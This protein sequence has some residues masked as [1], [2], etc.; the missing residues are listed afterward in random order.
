[1]EDDVVFLKVSSWAQT[2]IPKDIIPETLL[3]N[4]LHNC[5]LHGKDSIIVLKIAITTQLR[6][7][8]RAILYSISHLTWECLSLALWSE[9]TGKISLARFTFRPE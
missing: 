8:L 5:M 4:M 9:L 2:T 6:Q 3:V 7:K 1:M